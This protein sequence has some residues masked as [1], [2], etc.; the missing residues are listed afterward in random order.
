[1][2]RRKDPVRKAV[3]LR[4]F[5]DPAAEVVW[6][7]VMALD[8]ALQH[9]VLRELASTIAVAPA[10]RLSSASNKIRAA[11]A[12]LR[13]AHDLLGRSPSVRDYK[14]LRERFPELELPPESNI[15]LWLGG[16]WNDCLQRC[17]LPTVS[18]GDF[19]YAT[20]EE[21]FKEDELTT[22]ILACA[23]DLDKRPSYQDF[24]GWVR[25]PDVAKRFE[26]RPMSRAPF[27]RLGGWP[28]FLEKAGIVATVQRIDNPII[29]SIPRVYAFEKHE[30]LDALREVT[31][32]LS[33]T[34]GGR[35]PRI[36]EYD[37]ERIAI[38]K[39]SL[40]AGTPRAL[41]SSGTI[42]NAFGGWDKALIEAG[43]EPL[44]GR[45]T[46]SNPSARRATYS[47]EQKAQA[48]LDAWAEIGDPFIEDRYL[49][50]RDGKIAKAELR[51]EVAHVPSG[52]VIKSE[53]GGWREACVQNLP[54]YKPP[55]R[56]RRKRSFTDDEAESR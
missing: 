44:G 11:V 34:N 33:K 6:A 28:S 23:H 16:G 27:A 46:R 55:R 41:P 42:Y 29:R 49:D 37:G 10:D 35:S 39:E 31:E 18:D 52:D 4:V 38:H 26:R 56:R 24:K 40:A 48:L 43:L 7:G 51:G 30:M 12:A 22:L 53:F 54:G 15:R 21:D 13:E 50:W 9:E 17:L 36:N 8:V 20:L 5:T 25:R 2:P 3:R 1:M 19:A 32:R 14:E 45:A 47:R